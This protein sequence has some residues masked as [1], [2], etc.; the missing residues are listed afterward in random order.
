MIADAKCPVFILH[1][2]KDALIPASHSEELY[3]VCP[4]P[5]YLHLPDNMDHNEFMIDEDLIEPIKAFIRKI[6][7]REKEK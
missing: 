6:D 4:T 7:A 2:K 1:G 3:S 5:C